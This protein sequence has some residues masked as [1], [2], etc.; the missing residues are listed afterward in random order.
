[1]AGLIELR[2][3]G[4]LGFRH[5]LARRAIEQS[6]PEI[7]RRLL[8]QRVVAALRSR[9]RPD[10]GRLLHHAAEAGDV[11]TLLA[12]GPGRGA[13]GGAGRLAPPGAGA[14]RG[15]RPARRAAGAAR[16]RGAAGRLRL[17][18]LQRAP[19]PRGGRGRAR[20]GAA[21][22]R[23]RRTRPAGAVPGAAL[24]PSLHGGRDRRRRGGRAARGDHARRHRRRRRARPR[25]AVPGRDPGLEPARRGARGARARGRAGAALAPARPGGAVPELPRDRARGGRPGGR[26][27]DDAQLD[28]AG[29]G[30][31]APRGHRPRLHQ[32]RRAAA[33]ARA[34]RR[35]P[36]LRH[37][38]ADLHARAR[39]LVARLQPRGPPLPA[40]AAARRLGRR[41]GRPAAA[42]GGRRRS[43]D[44][45]RLQRALA[46]ARAGP[47]RRPGRRRPA[48]R[49]LGAGPAP[50]AAARAWPTPG[51]RAPSGPG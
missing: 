20:G 36:A 38:G 25:H 3:D 11:D 28:R 40:V 16:V 45:L 6:L 27:A 15:D 23:G 31:R 35:A 4:G 48:R 14:L 32:P 21:L 47:P 43:G 5:E 42:A 8:N 39:V 7:R 29:A 44:A 9:G 10:R 46:R 18:A 51:S 26:A 24:A 34:A 49:R 37:R 19:V 22:R 13:R 12:E 41:R 33:A 1:M 30:R 17:G 50:A 2:A